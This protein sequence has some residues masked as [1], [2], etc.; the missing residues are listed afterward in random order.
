MLE[1]NV[2]LKKYILSRCDFNIEIL[3]LNCSY[4]MTIQSQQYH[5]QWNNPTEY[6][7]CYLYILYGLHEPGRVTNRSSLQTRT[8]Q[9]LHIEDT[10]R[11]MLT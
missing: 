11:K 3:K 8:G 5:K 2:Q 4:V 1:H 10:F 6:T 7:S 9:D